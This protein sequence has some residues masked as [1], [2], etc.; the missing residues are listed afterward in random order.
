MWFTDWR[1]RQTRE[2]E[3]IPGGTSWGLPWELLT[4]LALGRGSPGS[5]LT[6]K[7]AAGCGEQCGHCASL[8]SVPSG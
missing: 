1:K 8:Y 6:D 4:S 5:S 3:E 2:K 7:Q